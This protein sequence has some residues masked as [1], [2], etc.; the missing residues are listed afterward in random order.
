MS[1]KPGQWVVVDTEAP[2]WP[3]LSKHKKGPFRI[4]HIDVGGQGKYVILEKAP[5]NAYFKEL[6]LYTPQ[7]GDKV[8]ILKPMINYSEEQGHLPNTVGQTHVIVEKY[9]NTLG[10]AKIQ[11][12][13]WW[14]FDGEGVY[15][16]VEPKGSI[17]A[18][19]QAPDAVK[20]Q[21]TKRVLNA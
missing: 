20:P 2:Y 10:Q 13:E 17:N 18:T 5:N 14:Y 4:S 1:F 11:I 9:T 16:L 19:V 21:P 15:E 6:T 8:K 7:V 12:G 3:N